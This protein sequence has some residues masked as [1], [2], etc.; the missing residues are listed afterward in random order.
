MDF[1]KELVKSYIEE[2]EML[3]KLRSHYFSMNR[4]CEP[5]Y[6]FYL[7][8]RDFYDKEMLFLRN[9]YKIYSVKEYARKLLDLK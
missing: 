6:I 3:K 8:V 1:S 7:M 4:N 2:E 5:D 9:V